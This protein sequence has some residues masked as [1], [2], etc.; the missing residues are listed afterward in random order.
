MSLVKRSI[1]ILYNNYLKNE[2]VIFF[3]I[4][5]SCWVSFVNSLVWTFVTPVLVVSLVSFYTQCKKM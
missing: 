4:F 1:F 3:F 5:F 2:T